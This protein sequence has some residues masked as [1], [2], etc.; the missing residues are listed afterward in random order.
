MKGRGTNPRAFEQFHPKINAMLNFLGSYCHDIKKEHN[1]A[2]F[3]KE[4][5]PVV[6]S[7]VDKYVD[8][9]VA[10]NAEQEDIEVQLV[11]SRQEVETLKTDLKSMETGKN[12]LLMKFIQLQNRHNLME[13]QYEEL[14][15]QT[16]L[17]QRPSTNL[18]FPQPTTSKMVPSHTVTTAQDTQGV[19]VQV[20]HAVVSQPGTS[21][22]NTT[23][24]SQTS[25]VQSTTLPQQQP[26]VPTSQGTNAAATCTAASGDHP[27]FTEP[28]V[29]LV[30]PVQ[31]DTAEINLTTSAFSPSETDFLNTSRIEPLLKHNLDDSQDE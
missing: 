2:R 20:L 16:V 28:N 7:K 26:C 8:M 29:P 27:P 3:V 31:F 19:T 18:P 12:D 30:S 17:V 4:V 24:L 15:K 22:D 14:R 6:M 1:L 13:A 9:E 10:E 23:P 25:T 5:M 21:G 11:Q